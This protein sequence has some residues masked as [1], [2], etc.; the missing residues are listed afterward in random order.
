MEPLL[1]IQKVFREVFGDQSLRISVEMR[2]VDLE[3]WDSVA[4]VQLILG[5]EREFGFRFTTDQV[6]Q[7]LGVSDLLKV[8]ASHG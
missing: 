2:A 4:T 6:A 7:I 5:V 3:D 8:V 1:R